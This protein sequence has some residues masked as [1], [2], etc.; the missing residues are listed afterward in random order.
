VC[1][2]SDIE[3]PI[4]LEVFAGRRERPRALGD[5]PAVFDEGT[6]G[7][8]VVRVGVVEAGRVVADV[9]R[10]PLVAL[11]GGPLADGEFD[12]HDGRVGGERRRPEDVEPAIVEPVRDPVE[13]FVELRIELIVDQ[14]RRVEPN[15]DRC[16][17]SALE[18]LA[19]RCVGERLRLG[20]GEVVRPRGCEELAGVMLKASDVLG[21]TDGSDVA[22]GIGGIDDDQRIVEARTTVLLGI[23][24]DRW[25]PVG[26]RLE[27]RSKATVL[28]DQEFGE[29]AA[30]PLCPEVA[31]VVADPLEELL[32][33][34]DVAGEI[35]VESLLEILCMKG[36]PVDRR[37]D[38]GRRLEAKAGD[39]VDIEPLD[40]AFD[41][42]M[43]GVLLVAVGHRRVADLEAVFF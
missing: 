30:K 33:D 34:S 24:L 23:E 6:V 18:V 35:V 4:T 10:W 39:D 11:D 28:T 14:V 7:V 25:V 2:E 38:A 37:P 40:L 8:G 13:R 19:E 3:E 27:Q 36:R 29:I 15:G 17:G 41:V 5:V 20:G 1:A 21:R 22:L 43:F 9:D 31:A 12:E 42:G 16:G 26:A 32:R